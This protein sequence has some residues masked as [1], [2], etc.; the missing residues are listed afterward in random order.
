MKFRPIAQTNKQ[1]EQVNR[2]RDITARGT[3]LKGSEDFRALL[4]RA[5]VA[6]N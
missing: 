3:V 5:S 4:I 6:R 1:S 2:I